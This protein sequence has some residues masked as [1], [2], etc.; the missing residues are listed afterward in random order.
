M[1]RKAATIA[2]LMLAVSALAYPAAAQQGATNPPTNDTLPGQLN[3]APD[4]DADKRATGA[5]ADD[6]E[7][8]A[9]P[10]DNP[11]SG[12]TGN[13]ANA[14]PDSKTTNEDG[15]ASALSD[16]LQDCG[17]VL[18]P[19]PTGETGIVEPPPDVGE[20]PIIPP[21]QLPG[22]QSADPDDDS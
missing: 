1:K 5:L 14:G 21:G 13:A 8:R 18:T 17:G 20:T 4:I 10:G 6:E 15:D 3:P 7:C 9:E 16:K 22:Q 19:P 11:S 2:A 12:A